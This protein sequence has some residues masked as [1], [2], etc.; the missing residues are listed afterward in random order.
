MIDWIKC[1]DRLPIKKENILCVYTEN[2]IRDDIYYENKWLRN[3]SWYD[4]YEITAWESSVTHWMPYP[5]PP[6]E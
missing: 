3:H 1:S 2:D 6:E 5:K 4:E